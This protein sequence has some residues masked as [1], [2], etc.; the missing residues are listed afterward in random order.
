LVIGAAVSDNGDLSRG[1]SMP[2][3][4]LI[5]F[6]DLERN[7]PR[8]IQKRTFSVHEMTATERADG[9]EQRIARETT[10]E[11]PAVDVDELRD[12][13]NGAGGSLQAMPLTNQQIRQQLAAGRRIAPIWCVDDVKAERPDLSDD[14]CWELLQA[15]KQEHDANIGINWSV[16]RD[17]AYL[18]FG[19]PTAGPQA[20]PD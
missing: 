1:G 7:A 10:V 19:P 4:P 3:A 2:V 9:C 17:A 8:V 20:Q 12:R 13:V 5:R 6:P 11:P 16:I 15:I 18:M 14:Q